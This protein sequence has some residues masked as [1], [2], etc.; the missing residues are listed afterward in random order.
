MGSAD[1][2]GETA[3]GYDSTEECDQGKVRKAF[4]E[5]YN[6]LVVAK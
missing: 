1:K 6:I 5:N 2:K 4:V 3:I